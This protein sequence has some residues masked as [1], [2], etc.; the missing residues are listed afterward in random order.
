VFFFSFIG[1]F[2]YHIPKLREEL[3]IDLHQVQPPTLL[4]FL[5]VEALHKIDG[6]H[7]ATYEQKIISILNN[8]EDMVKLNYFAFLIE[9]PF[10]FDF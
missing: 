8:L 4:L 1:F 6:D 7:Y 5:V 2:L 3:Q 10:S 9:P